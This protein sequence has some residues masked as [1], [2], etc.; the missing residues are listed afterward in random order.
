[1]SK[2][3]HN[4]RLAAPLAALAI[5]AGCATATPYQPLGYPGARGGY[6]NQQL[7]Q[8]HWRVSFVGNSLTSRE[9]VENYLLYRAAELTLQ[10]GFNCFTVVNRDT[11]RNVRVQMDPY[12]P[13]GGFGGFGR[14]GGY[15]PG[16]SPYWNMYGPWGRHYY[17]PWLGGPFFPRQYDLRT[18]S[19]YQA[20]ADIALSRGAC[21][22]SPGTFNAAQIVQN[23]RPYIM[24]PRPA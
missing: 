2:W 7:D 13:Y 21:T 19:N 23:L 11:D 16:W 22:T 17:D 15:Y 18:I 5:L 12:G 9:Q 14:Y 8:T 24:M 4:R 3:K 1:M 6:T 20:T 10:Q